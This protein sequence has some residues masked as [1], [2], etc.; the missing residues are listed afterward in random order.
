[1][2][3]SAFRGT[4]EFLARVGVYDV[5]LPFILVFTIVFAILE[6]TKIYGVDNHPEHGKTSRKNLNAM[7]A[8]VMAFFVVA[9]S[10]LVEIIL[11]VSS[12]IIVLLLLG[13][14]F[15]ILV[16][17]F[18]TG[19]DELQLS[20][21]WKT[22]FMIIMFVGIVLIFLNAV[23]WLGSAYDYVVHHFNSTAVSAI[24]LIVVI[25][26]FMIYIIKEPGGSKKKNKKDKK[27]GD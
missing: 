20:D 27:E 13:V 2:E 24:I 21:G 5:V 17:V 11:H 16:G 26:G 10:Q 25:L 19:P 4:L 23:G 3:Q 14:F 22:A 1:M 6:K 8:F 12:Q 18:H 7:T 9:S 15:L